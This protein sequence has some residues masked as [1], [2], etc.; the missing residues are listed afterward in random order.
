[1]PKTPGLL[2]WNPM[3]YYSSTVV[4]KLNLWP[5]FQTK[6]RSHIQW[7]FF[8]IQWFLNWLLSNQKV[9]TGQ[10]WIFHPRRFLLQLLVIKF[11]VQ[12]LDFVLPRCYHW[13]CV[14]FF[15]LA[16]GPQTFSVKGQMI[17]ISGFVVSV[18]A[19]QLCC[20]KFRTE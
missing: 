9:R 10:G 7:F 19:A 2:F 16:W 11:T 3:S 1:M 13:G 14:S 5:L 6:C 15:A 18:S 4:S 8:Y 20:S 12:I 17:K